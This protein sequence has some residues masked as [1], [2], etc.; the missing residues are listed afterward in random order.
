MIAIK[1]KLNKKNTGLGWVERLGYGLGGSGYYIYI[2]TIGTY[3]VIYMTNVA[4]LDI[5]IISTLIVVSKVFDGISDLAAGHILDRTKTPLGKARPWLLIMCVPL[6]L[7]TWLLFRVPAGLP[8]YAK[9][10]YVFILYNLACTV[11]LTFVQIAHFSLV[12]LM[13]ENKEEQ[14]FLGVIQSIF[15]NVGN[16]LGTAL[17][18]KLLFLFT[19]D[20]KNQNTQPAY[21]GAL[22]VCGLVVVVT[23][24]ITVVTT[25]E[26]VSGSI[27]RKAEV[28]DASGK[29]RFS[30]LDVA[31]A[32]IGDKNWVVLTLA[33]ILTLAGA[34]F[35]MLGG[36]YYALYILKDMGQMAWMTATVLVTSLLIMFLVPL[37]MKKWSKKQIFIIGNALVALGSLGFGLFAW[38]RTGMIFSNVLRGCGV[39]VSAGIQLGLVADLIRMTDK[40]KGIH[41]VGLGNAGISAAT[42]IGMGLGNVFF[43]FAMAAVGFSAAYDSQGLP[44]PVGV[45]HMIS[46]MYIW[47]PMIVYLIAVIL[48]IIFFDNEEETIDAEHDV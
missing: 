1:E 9:Y 21:S 41:A 18:V 26:R 19:N 37:M 45:N 25:R 35:M 7:S 38:S 10:V 17:F 44:Q 40:K 11:F 8:V 5:A 27:S 36:S 20:P 48:L 24:L 32:L 33:Q 47:G 6:A 22:L 42:K 23:L 2:A 13:T 14:G 46:W 3:L 4:M 15:T 29:N 16:V 12:S 43:G 34:Q 39:G 28:P 31:K 30:G